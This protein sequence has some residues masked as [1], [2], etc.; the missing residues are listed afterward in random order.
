MPGNTSSLPRESG[1]T[2]N[3]AFFRYI[4]E[5]AI[6]SANRIV[7]LVIQSLGVN[8]VLDVGCGAGAWLS[9]YRQQGITD[10]LGVDGTY[11]Q[12]DSL[13]IPPQAFHAQDLAQHFDLQ[14]KFDL[15]QC[16]EVGEHIPQ[17]AS[18]TLVENLVR[19][20]KLVL[21]S[22]AIPG[23]GGE[24]H[25]NEQPYEFWR[26]LFNLHG[27]K[28]LDFVRSRIR[29]FADVEK[30]YRYNV[31]LYAAPEIIAALPSVVGSTRVPDGQPIA[32]V[33]R[34]LYKVRTRLFS[35]LPVSWLTL[36]ALAKHRVVLT[37]RAVVR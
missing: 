13:L 30:W 31:V 12:Q 35:Y 20:G 4:H 22:A 26:R 29:S 1:Y 8:S 23:Q 34:G 25:I 2:Y 14:R 16:L 15:V 9:V 32:N 24:H 10:I 19:H 3:E 27:Y 33:A 18:K 17:P 37:Y 5:G 28:P 21:F 36:I 7:P 11:V 6:R